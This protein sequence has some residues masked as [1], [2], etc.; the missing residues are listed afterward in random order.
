MFG[1]DVISATPLCKHAHRNCS[2]IPPQ[3]QSSPHREHYR[4]L[5]KCGSPRG[6]FYSFLQ[7]KP[8][9]QT[10]ANGLCIK[11]VWVWGKDFPLVLLRRSCCK[12]N[13]YNCYSLEEMSALFLI[14]PAILFYFFSA[15]MSSS[16]SSSPSASNIVMLISITVTKFLYHYRH[17]NCQHHHVYTQLLP[18]S[19]SL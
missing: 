7:A 6:L 1:N 9:T 5:S 18:P 19:S 3:L 10:S 17:P 12:H 2:S 15:L 16:L 8:I 4:C 14:F 13:L 11:S